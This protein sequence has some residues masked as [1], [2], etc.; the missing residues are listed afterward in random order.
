LYSAAERAPRSQTPKTHIFRNPGA[1]RYWP[2]FEC[3]S[4]RIVLRGQ[5]GRVIFREFPRRYDF[6]SRTSG[7]SIR[8]RGAYEIK[9]ADRNRVATSTLLGDDV[10]NYPVF[11]KSPTGTDA[12]MR[13]IHRIRGSSDPGGHLQLAIFVWFIRT[14]FDLPRPASVTNGNE[15]MEMELSRVRRAR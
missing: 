8:D 3:E 13:P 15:R 2:C 1:S 6:E 11:L 4:E 5:R 12:R 9:N 7:G 10:S 14:L